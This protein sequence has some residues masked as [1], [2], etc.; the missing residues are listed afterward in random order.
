MT[1][2]VTLTS[3]SPFNF[4]VINYNAFQNACFKILRNYDIL[5]EKCLYKL[6]NYKTNGR[7][8]FLIGNWEC[9]KGQEI[10]F[11]INSVSVRQ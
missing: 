7:E 6:Y 11:S 10:L 8:I 2:R 4:V 9:L 1:S 5:I 3:Y